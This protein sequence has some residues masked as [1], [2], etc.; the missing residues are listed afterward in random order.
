MP[1]F[2]SQAL[3]RRPESLSLQSGR[4]GEQS[5]SADNANRL[6]PTKSSPASHGTI[7]GLHRFEGTA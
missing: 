4:P 5:V 2:R 1:N 3:L 6:A 7:Q